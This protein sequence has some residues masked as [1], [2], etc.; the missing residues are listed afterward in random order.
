MVT[1]FG[2]ILRQAVAQTPGAVGSALAARDGELVDSWTTLDPIDWAV[3]TAHFGIVVNHMR[4]AL[5][6]FHFGDLELVYFSYHE[7]D[8]AVQIVTRDYFAILA[9]APPMHLQA[10]TRTLHDTVQ[11]LHREMV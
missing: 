10:T 5:H 11:N 4:C 3:L 7:L 2:D 8:L 6:T 9:S 1:P